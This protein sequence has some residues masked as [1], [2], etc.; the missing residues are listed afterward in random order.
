MDQVP[1][2]QIRTAGWIFILWFSASIRTV[3]DGRSMVVIDASELLFNAVEGSPGRST[4]DERI[5]LYLAAG[6][7][8]I[9]NSLHD[10]DS[11]GKDHFT[12]TTF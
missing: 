2:V 7:I 4:A 12:D 11:A 10:A 3:A 1:N 5:A 8:K 6:G 9:R